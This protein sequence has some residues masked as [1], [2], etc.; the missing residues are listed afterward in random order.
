[1]FK[2]LFDKGSYYEVYTTDRTWFQRVCYWLLNKTY[3]KRLSEPTELLRLRK[4]N[5]YLEEE[6]TRYSRKLT[7]ALNAYAAH[8]GEPAY[9]MLWG[10]L[11][12]SEE[13][14]VVVQTVPNNLT[15]PLYIDMD[16]A[17]FMHLM[18]QQEEMDNG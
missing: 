14:D 8:I 9:S 4:R 3:S 17:K 12:M 5:E 13:R 18:K 2:Y 1:M 11:K 15:E 10:S 7:N 16:D 6:V